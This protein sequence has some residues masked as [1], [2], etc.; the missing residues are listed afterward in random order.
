MGRG[1]YLGGKGLLFGGGLV[2]EGGGENGGVDNVFLF[3]GCNSD[4]LFFSMIIGS[5]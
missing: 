4:R 3:C 5:F 1:Y 2:F